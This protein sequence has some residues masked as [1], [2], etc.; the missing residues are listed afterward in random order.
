MGMSALILGL[1]GFAEGMLPGVLLAKWF[2]R[3]QKT[4]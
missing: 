1:E 3:P 4:K 2:I